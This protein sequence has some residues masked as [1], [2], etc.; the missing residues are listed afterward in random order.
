MTA[1]AVGGVWVYA[2]ELARA[3]C[4]DGYKVMLVANGPRPRS[5]QVRPLR[6]VRGLELR[7]TDLRLEWMDPEG[8]DIERAGDVLLNTADEFRPDIVHLNSF[9]E[10]ILDWPA[11]A[12]VVAHSCVQ[13]WWRACRGGDLSEAR[14]R[15]YCDRVAAGLS[16]ADVWVAP[17]AAFR[18]AIV[19]TYHLS[20][21]GRVIR[22]G[23][24][25]CVPTLM[26]RPVILGAGR[27]WDE[28]KN[29]AAVVAIASDLP[30]PIHL[31]G[32]TRGPDGG[33]VGTS[34]GSVKFLGTLPR[35][36][37]LDEM[38]S[39]SI[40][41]APAL[42]EPFGLTV[43]EAGACGCALVL[44]DLPS[45]RELWDDAALFVDPHDR[46]AIRTAL[47]SLCWDKDLRGGLQAKARSRASDFSQSAMAGAYGRLYGE[48]SA[49]RMR[50]S[51][52]RGNSVMELSA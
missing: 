1:D 4:E 34:G 8:A 17:T 31:A 33:R 13:T 38:G 41:V 20:N 22:N 15:L 44:S 25:V 37:L 42:Y 24:S 7:V 3:L 16:A 28:A 30:W 43:L 26:K 9:R 11:P 18:D 46:N 47:Q 36:A 40:F 21:Q 51:A 48:M 35:P 2:V 27:L 14:W 23:L 19:A 6:G 49:S 10:A 32:E 45:F 29:L 5:D 39:A 52:R 50:A 12:V